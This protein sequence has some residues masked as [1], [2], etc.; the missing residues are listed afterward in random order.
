MHNSQYVNPEEEVDLGTQQVQPGAEAISTYVAGRIAVGQASLT[1]QVRG[2]SAHS[3]TPIYYSST[4]RCPP[5][6]RVERACS[7]R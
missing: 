6:C 5:Y 7:I 3:L 4:N 2:I 1:H